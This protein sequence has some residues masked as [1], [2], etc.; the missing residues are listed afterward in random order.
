[1]YDRVRSAFYSLECPF[2]NMLSRLGEHLDRHIVRYH[3]LLDQSAQK[4]IFCLRRCREPDFD[5]F[6]PDIHEKLEKFQF[7]IQAHRLDQRLIA[8]AEIHAAPDG[9]FINSVFF[10]PVIAWFRRHKISLFVFLPVFHF[11]TS[12]YI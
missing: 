5:H 6:K 4:L 2:D 8:V 12:P 3:I 7:F 1:M 11:C 10:H 9:R